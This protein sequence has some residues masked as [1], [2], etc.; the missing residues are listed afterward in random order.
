LKPSLRALGL[1]TGDL[2]LKTFYAFTA[3]ADISEIVTDACLF[4]NETGVII[5]IYV[6][7]LL[8]IATCRQAILDTA[9]KLASKFDL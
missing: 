3:A 8:I 9:N 6:D 7:D 4:R 2:P 5:V 1:T